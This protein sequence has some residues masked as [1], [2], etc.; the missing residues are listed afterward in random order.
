MFLQSALRQDKPYL[1]VNYIAKQ[2]ALQKSVARISISIFRENVSEMPGILLC[3]DCQPFLNGLQ[4]QAHCPMIA[5][6]AITDE[7]RSTRIEGIILRPMQ[8]PMFTPR[9]AIKLP[10]SRLDKLFDVVP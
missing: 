3:Q 7:Q 1:P 4:V 8:M 5:V 2:A 10:K 9:L 6:F